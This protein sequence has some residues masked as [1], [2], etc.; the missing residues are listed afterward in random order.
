V[1]ARGLRTDDELDSRWNSS[2]QFARGDDSVFTT[3][4]PMKMGR[5]PG[6]RSECGPSTTTCSQRVITAA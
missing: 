6:P 5:R 1:Q 3:I 4:P 2:G